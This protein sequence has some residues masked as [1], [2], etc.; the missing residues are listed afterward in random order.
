SESASTDGRKADDLGAIESRAAWLSPVPDADVPASLRN[1]PTT[2][3]AR[4]ASDRGFLP[5]TLD[6]YLELLDWTGRAVRSDK[7]GSIPA[8]LLPILQRLQVNA[9]AWVDTIEQFGRTFRRAVG[10]I[11]SLAA[12]AGAKGKCWFQ[13]VTASKLAFG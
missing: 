7:R 4:R 6:E 12:L 2:G 8:N 9:D 3:S 10:R 11:S 1:V 5:M 13:G